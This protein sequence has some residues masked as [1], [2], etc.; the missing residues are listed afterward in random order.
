MTQVVSFYASTLY[1][2]MAILRLEKHYP[3]TQA[4]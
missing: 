1:F 3:L 2:F 4:K